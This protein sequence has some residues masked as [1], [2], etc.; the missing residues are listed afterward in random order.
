MLGI[1]KGAEALK[2]W[3]AVSERFLKRQDICM[4]ISPLYLP[5]YLTPNL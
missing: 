3:L 4:G 2:R 1:V 5:T